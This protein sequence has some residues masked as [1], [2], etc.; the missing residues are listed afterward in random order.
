MKGK[1]RGMISYSSPLPSGTPT[2]A[3]TLCARTHAHPSHKVK[4]LELCQ[5]RNQPHTPRIT[6]GPAASLWQQH[7]PRPSLPPK[8]HRKEWVPAGLSGWTGK[9]GTGRFMPRKGEERDTKRSTNSGQLLRNL[10]LT[11]SQGKPE[12]EK[13]LV[14]LTQMHSHF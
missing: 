5:V 4:D 8:Q 14:M 2:T 1:P 12:K 10:L 11:L 9:P 3:S 13:L 7:C 6:A